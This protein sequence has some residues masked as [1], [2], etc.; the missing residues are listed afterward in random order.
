MN[1]RPDIFTYL[2]YRQYLRDW[3][4][5][6]KAGNPRFSHRAFARRAGQSSPSLLLHVMDR[7]RNLTAAT[8]ESFCKAMDLKGEDADF[9]ATLVALDQAESHED[10]NRA[11]EKV[12]ATRRFRDARRIE[13][14]GFEYLSRWYYAAI[15]E[16]AACEDFRPDPEWIAWALRPKIT[17]EQARAAIDLLLR[18]GLLRAEP[19]GSLVPA[20]GSVVTPHE[21]AGLA[22][23]NFHAAMIERARESIGQY[24]AAERHYCSVT[25]SVPLSLVPKLKRELDGFQE[26]LLD[27]C[28]SADPPRERVF[29]INFQLLPLSV[30]LPI[31]EK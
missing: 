19:D 7:K 15:R 27:L 2:D 26:R 20:E 14:D 16:L 30:P 31:T 29:Q 8:I 18:L 23:S 11:W 5:A 10:R 4:T 28:D 9:F 13:G 6:R 17:E 24:K 1:V 25:V 12:S 21:V 3:F 22:A